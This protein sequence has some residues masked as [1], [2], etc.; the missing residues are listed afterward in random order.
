[1]TD[2][3]AFSI[4]VIRL[5]WRRP[6]SVRMSSVVQTIIKDATIYVLVLCTSRII[7]VF[8]LVFSKVL[9]TLILHNA[10]NVEP[11]TSSR[12]SVKPPD[13][14]TSDLSMRAPPPFNRFANTRVFHSGSN[15]FMS[16]M[17]TRMLL[18]LKRTAA[19]GSDQGWGVSGES[20]S[21]LDLPCSPRIVRGSLRFSNAL[22][23]AKIGNGIPIPMEVIHI[24]DERYPV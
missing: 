3:G 9:T 12:A 4:I 1:M 14:R 8:L 11:E 6:P 18:S 23:H 24:R 19:K 20:D 10:C 13:S 16:I 7:F 21:M 5:L 17:I 22:S 2:V 15:V